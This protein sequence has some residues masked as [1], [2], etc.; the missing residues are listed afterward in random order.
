MSVVEMNPLTV[1]MTSA[2][3][4]RFPFDAQRG[5][6]IQIELPPAFD[7]DFKRLDFAGLNIPIP[8][9]VTSVCEM[10]TPAP[11]PEF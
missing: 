6:V 7:Q 2:T 5:I 3:G 1:V 9:S 4:K 10:P 8:S 11:P